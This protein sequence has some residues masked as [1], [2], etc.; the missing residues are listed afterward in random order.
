MHMNLRASNNFDFV[1]FVASSLVLFSHSFS[2]INKSNEDLLYIIFDGQI[3]SGRLAVIVFFVISGFLVSASFFNRGSFIS[4]MSARVKRII[5]GLA[6]MLF[7]TVLFCFFLTTENNIDYL[8]SSIKYFVNN[9]SLYRVSYFLF[10]V[11]EDNPFGSAVNGSLWTLR[12]EFSCYLILA[13]L[14]TIGF[15]RRSV[16]WLIWVVSLALSLLSDV[17]TTFL[18]EFFPLLVW[19]SSGMLAYL[20]RDLSLR[21]N[22]YFYLVAIVFVLVVSG[23]G[24]FVSPILAF[25]LIKLVYVDG[26]FSNFGKYGD[27]SYGIYIYAFPIQQFVVYLI[28]KSVLHPMAWW[29]VFM[30]SFPLTLLFAVASWHLVEKRFLKVGRKTA[31]PIILVAN[32]R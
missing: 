7:L 31:S 15:F 6:M 21:R 27:F 10:G 22:L 12:L 28:T 29:V 26:P 14:G 32:P 17:P 19:F 8:I 18:K 24:H 23:L 16:V 11:F 9:I 2:L 25:L 13:F 4:F 3:T 30:V 20:Y 5:P 1:R